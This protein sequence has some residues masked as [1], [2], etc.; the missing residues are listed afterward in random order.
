VAATPEYRGTVRR[1]IIGGVAV[2]RSRHG[3]RCRPCMTAS[4]LSAAGRADLER[5]HTGFSRLPGMRPA[6][7]PPRRLPSELRG[8]GRLVAPSMP[9]IS[10]AFPAGR[11]QPEQAPRRLLLV[12]DRNPKAVDEALQGQLVDAY[13]GHNQRRRT[14][15]RPPRANPNIAN[16]PGSGTALGSTPVN[17]KLCSSPPP[18]KLLA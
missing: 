7:P 1:T 16:V 4:A 2:F 6:T 13:L 15:N 3:L 17:A 8:T 18:V 5:M 12:V 14:V 9:V 11:T 10:S